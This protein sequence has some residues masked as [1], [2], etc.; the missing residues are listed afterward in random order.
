MIKWVDDDDPCACCESPYHT[1]EECP[2]ARK[3]L[4]EYK[5]REERIE[6][7]NGYMVNKYDNY[8][9]TYPSHSY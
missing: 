4:E 5:E 8:E 2:I 7:R 1:W 6:F 9:D 3:K